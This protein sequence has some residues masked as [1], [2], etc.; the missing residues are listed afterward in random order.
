[1]QHKIGLR[2]NL[3]KEMGT[4]D[5]MS[6]L[7]PHIKYTYLLISLLLLFLMV[8]AIFAQSPHPKGHGDD[9]LPAYRDIRPEH[10]TEDP[11]TSHNRDRK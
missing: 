6:R 1:M 5:K 3:S 11:E 8:Q 7:I 2:S 9:C 10:A 4:K